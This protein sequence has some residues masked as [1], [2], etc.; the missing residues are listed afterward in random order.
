MKLAMLATAALLVLIPLSARGHDE[1]EWIQN[2]PEFGW[3]CSREDCNPSPE[4]AVHWTPQGYAVDGL[5]GTLDEG[6]RGF[7][8]SP[9]VDR[10]WHCAI[11]GTQRL[12]C[13]FMPEGQG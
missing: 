8:R 6:Q 9:A 10:P 7:Y 3:C 4:G 11:P 13:L 5:F 12:R 2:H 1:A